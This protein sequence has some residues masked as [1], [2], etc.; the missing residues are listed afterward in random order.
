[1]DMQ[2]QQNVQQ[3]TYTHTHGQ[4]TPVCD[5]TEKM[6]NCWTGLTDRRDGNNNN[7][8]QT[9]Q[10]AS[11]LQ[12]VKVAQGM[13]NSSNK[14]TTTTT[15]TTTTTRPRQLNTQSQDILAAKTNKK[16]L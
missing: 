6:T 5:M 12:L 3:Q 15:P 8:C 1:M 10:V 9:L 2:I 11:A 13:N 14:T 4:Q 7:N 16:L